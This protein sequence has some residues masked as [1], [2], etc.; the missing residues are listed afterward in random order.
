[1]KRTV[2]LTVQVIVTL[3][4]PMEHRNRARELFEGMSWKILEAQEEPYPTVLLPGG[5][6]P[7]HIDRRATYRLAVPIESGSAGR[8]EMLA[9]QQVKDLAEAADMDLR[10]K[11]ADFSRR[12]RLQEPH[13]FVCARR[14][15]HPH[16]LIRWKSNLE[17]RAGLHDTGTV[18]FG[19]LAEVE[20]LVGPGCARPPFRRSLQAHDGSPRLRT[21]SAHVLVLQFV[22]VSWVAALLGIPVASGRWWMTVPALAA[23]ALL[24]SWCTAIVLPFVARRRHAWL[25]ALLLGVALF[26]VTLWETWWAGPM[27]ALSTQL[28]LA[29]ALFVTAGIRRLVRSGSPRPF[30]VAAAVALLPVVLP[31]LLGLSPALL[32]FYG[33]AFNVRA[34]DMDVAEAQQFLASTYVLAISVGLVLFFLACWGYLQPLFRDHMP[35]LALPLAYMIGIMALALAFMG[36][37]LDGAYAKGGESVEQWRSGKVPGHYY[38][39]NPQ[40]VCVNPIRPVERLPAD[41]QRLDPD[42]VYGSFGVVDGQVTL[43]DPKS[44]DSFPVPADAVQVLTAGKGTPGSSIPRDCRS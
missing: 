11:R 44:G 15:E 3:T 23:W 6:S 34:E 35:R 36:I 7:G 18:L 1:M 32:T 22:T 8:P 38:G 4:G 27:S 41:G 13:W 20:Y 37:V 2:F 9:S 43:W 21:R 30:L 40:P 14:S 25:V 16:P 24:M 17:R 31:T 26:E 10:P 12:Q 33:S 19:S 28:L 39:A 5:D 42:R 29:G